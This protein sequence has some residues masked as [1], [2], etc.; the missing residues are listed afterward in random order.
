MGKCKEKPDF[1]NQIQK[2]ELQRFDGLTPKP[3]S[4]ILNKLEHILRDD[5]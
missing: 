4:K 1:L 3:S 5:N 2:I